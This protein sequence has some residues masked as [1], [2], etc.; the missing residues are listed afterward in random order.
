M[1]AH[2]TAAQLA[3]L[4]GMPSTE[5]AVQIRA[6][7]AAWPS[8]KR[9]GRGGGNEYPLQALPVETQSHLLLQ[10]VPSPPASKAGTS[11]KAAARGA[12]S[13][14]PRSAETLWEIYNRAPQGMKDEALRKHH[15]VCVVAGL[16]DHGTGITKALAQVA[17][18][19]LIPAK[20]LERWWYQDIKGYD[21][22]DWLA[23]LM[24]GYV[25]R[26]VVADFDEM[27][28]DWFKRQY[29]TRDQESLASA[30]RRLVE[31]ADKQGWKVPSL[32][33]VANRIEREIP[34]PQLV[35]L[36]EG[37]EALMR[38]YPSQSRDVACF[39]AGQA[40]NGDGL[41]FDKLW[42]DFGDEIINTATAW[43]FSDLQSGKILAH[44]EA[45]TENIDVFR[46]AAYDLYQIT[47]PEHLWVDNTVVAANK[48]MTAG[49]QGRRRFKDQPD[50]FLGALPRLGTQ[51]HFTDPDHEVTTPGSKPIER[52][53]GIGGIHSAVVSHPSLKG[54]G[55]SKATAI[56]VAEFK[57]V[58]A[59][60]I[61]RH[62]AQPKRRSRVCG[63]VLSFD[64]AWEQSIAK[65]VP[66]RVT[67]SQRR[68]LLLIPEMVFAAREN[69]TITVKAGRG[70]AGQNRY[71]HEALVEYAGQKLVAYL[72]PENLSNPAS[73][74]TLDGRFIVDAQHLATTAFNDTA[75]GREWM[76]GKK[77]WLKSQKDSA[78]EQQRMGALEAAA[79]YPAAP[80]APTEPDSKVVRLGQT[81]RDAFS[82]QPLKRA[83]GSDLTDTFTSNVASMEEAFW[84]Q[85]NSL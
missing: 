4:P 85:R 53:F 14:E 38:K 84:R 42:I 74:H 82:G 2:Y 64:Q 6:K 25:G 55:Y 36:R 58:L 15:A 33:A 80:V 9:A 34:A 10:Q 70:P 37:P 13:T 43:V 26:T 61:R 31:T 71:W 20:T 46:L 19:M 69:G 50:D 52:K 66:R 12:F 67:E 44:R 47:A 23:A 72:D 40:V 78:R 62:N 63:G 48:A 18:D 24:D 83:A 79:L 8:R 57:A 73:V 65:T 5:R 81:K 51:V 27:A 32:P 21:R 3:G 59:E 60:E 30:Y 22:K 56:P 54:R 17:A 77:R 16:R 75:T 35:F 76:K 39:T 28:W 49:A 45:K 41:K 11:P 7:K 29:L 1:S 68:V